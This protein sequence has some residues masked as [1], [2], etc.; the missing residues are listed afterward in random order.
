MTSA[1][2]VS[3]IIPAFNEQ[4]T[5]RAC[6]LAAIHQSVAASEIIVVDNLS[7]DRTAEIVHA[8]MA[9]FPEAP[10]RFLSQTAAQG[11]V[12]TRNLGFDS[13]AGDILGRIDADSVVEPTWVEKVQEAFEDDSVAAATGPVIYYDMPL[14][15]F[16]LRAD[17]AMRR[18]VFTVTREFH[19]LFG[20]NMAL[21][22]S[23]WQEIRNDTC[24]DLADKFHEDVDL[25]IHLHEHDLTVAYC[26]SM[27]A[28]ISARRLD[29]SAAKFFDYVMRFERT[30][31]RHGVKDKAVRAPMLVFL[32][33][34]PALKVMRALSKSTLS[35]S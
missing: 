5:I 19:L 22:R 34:Y 15:R 2:N 29:D 31:E 3:I 20:S 25:A 10:L 26:S 17:D 12:P 30:Y 33:A 13:A 28:G 9:A 7:T 14:R 21:R 32:A 8:L 11:I 6:V 27:V 35:R 24:I 4:D 23:A 1:L 16:G 18:A